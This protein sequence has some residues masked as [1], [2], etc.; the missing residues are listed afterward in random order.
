M[1]DHP[2]ATSL[3][4]LYEYLKRFS[5]SDGLFIISIV[6]N[7]FKYGH[8]ALNQEVPPNTL[9]WIND[10]CK[11]EPRERFALCLYLS[12]LARFLL[13]SRANDYKSVILDT[14]TIE[15]NNAL[16]L[17]GNLHEKEIEGEPKS[18][19]DMTPIMGRIG[20]LQFPFQ[21]DR[22]DIMGRGYLLFIEIP[23]ILNLSYNFD[24]KMKEYF[25]LDVYQ[26]IASGFATWM[27]STG[28]LKYQLTIDIV[29]LKD[30]VT[31]E[32][33]NKFV[34][35][36]SGT[37]EDYRKYIRGDDWKT[38]NKL[39]D[40]HSLDPFFKMPAVRVGK[41]GKLQDGQFVVP[42]P[43][44]LLYRA[45]L[46][47]FH[48]LGDKERDMALAEGKTGKNEFREAFGKVYRE[49]IGRQLKQTKSPTLFI[50]LD[51]EIGTEIKKPDFAIIKDDICILFEVK[52]SFLTL[53]PRI[54]FDKD[55]AKTE[56]SNENG[57][58]KKALDQLTIFEKAILNNEVTDNR[59]KDIKKVVKVIVGFEDIYFANAFLLPLAKEIYGEQINNLQVATLSDI[60]IIGTRLA[61]GGDVVSALLEKVS[62]E[63][64]S[65]WSLGAFIA[66][67]TTV[68]K[69]NN[70]ILRR[71]FE[72]LMT[73][74]SGEDYTDGKDPF[75]TKP[76]V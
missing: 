24:E 62:S 66:Q 40:I 12:R 55:E 32:T 45:S 43:L 58:F 23:K 57:N 6:N 46:G 21:V 64:I 48:L 56:V 44:Y 71:A 60:E 5:L 73:K 69:D 31:A 13:L 18:L 25:G 68:P 42:Q 20:Q 67:K 30:F 49:Y 4:D 1:S 10:R 70:P 26:F 36:S 8:N 53:N 22:R 7:A 61:L 72:D 59:L 19:R 54:F 38:I 35:L 50:D 27:M 34:E 75:K 41:S 74:I 52:T 51:E 16:F 76:T 33:L 15:M 39:L 29:A 3:E 9:A 63:D 14:G 17:V 11:D 2:P 47:I 37:P 65:E 28:V